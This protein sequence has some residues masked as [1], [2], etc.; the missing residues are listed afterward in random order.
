MNFK[1]YCEEVQKAR[2]SYIHAFHELAHL[3]TK[4]VGTDY[5][6]S[7]CRE[8]LRAATLIRALESVDI[9]VKEIKEDAL[10]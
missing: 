5:N 3:E 9:P 10:L 7:L 2:N 1:R 8:L 4:Q 6:I